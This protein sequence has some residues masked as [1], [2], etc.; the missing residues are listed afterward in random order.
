MYALNHLLRY[1]VIFNYITA[2]T[3]VELIHLFEQS[4]DFPNEMPCF[5]LACGFDALSKDCLRRFLYGPDIDFTHDLAVGLQLYLNVLGAAE[6][7]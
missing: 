2:E 3:C 4:M 5:S 6:R 7:N 1:H